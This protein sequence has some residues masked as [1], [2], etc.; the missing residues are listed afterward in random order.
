MEPGLD[1]GL[2]LGSANAPLE[3]VCSRGLADDRNVASTDLKVLELRRIDNDVV[4]A[5]ELPLSFAPISYEE[6]KGLM[7]VCGEMLI[8]R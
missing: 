1:P 6:S 3:A 8:E 2:S 7:V 5:A 4:L